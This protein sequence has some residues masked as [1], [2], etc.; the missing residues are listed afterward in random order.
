MLW[1]SICLRNFP[2]RIELHLINPIPVFGLAYLSDWTNSAGCM[3]DRMA[4]PKR[5]LIE[6][7]MPRGRRHKSNA[8]V[9]MFVAIPLH[10]S[11][12]PLPCHLN[13]RKRL[14][15]PAVCRDDTQRFH[16]RLEAIAPRRRAIVRMLHQGAPP[17]ALR[18]CASNSLMHN[19]KTK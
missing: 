2:I 16:L 12:Y 1:V 17:T 10:K 18:P 6:P 11:L 9:T 7:V 15:Q 5:I 3:M 8:A 19:F 14:A 4:T 13:A